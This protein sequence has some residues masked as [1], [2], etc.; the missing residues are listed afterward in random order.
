MTTAL[1]TAWVVG[2]SSGIGAALAR[3]LTSRGYQVAISARDETALQD[4][5]AG[6]MA[7]VQVDVTDRESVLSAASDA[8]AALGRVDLAVFLAGVWEQMSSRRFDFDTFKKHVDVN[9][10]GMASC[11]D[12][13]L[14]T[15]QRQGRGTILGV[16]SLAGYRGFPGAEGYG[17]TKAAQINLLESMRAG[18][19]RTGVSVLTACPGFVETP[20]TGRNAFPMPFMISPET[21]AR[22]LADGV[23]RGSPLIEFPWQMSLLMKAARLV[24]AR[25]WP[26]L[27]RGEA[28]R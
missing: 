12:A 20:L 7:V 6:S 26:L 8:E 16:A 19:S 5:A 24:P 15:M 9:L 1:R 3:E 23:E 17:A 18:L 11:I 14:P 27:A 25:L 4:V 2:A 22:H 21:A 28:G 13:V 10:L